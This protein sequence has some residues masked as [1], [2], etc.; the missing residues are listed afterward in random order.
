MRW[1]LMFTVCS[2]GE[3]SVLLDDSQLS[4]LYT[5]YE[6]C[7]LAE[8]LNPASRPVC[9]GP[10]PARPGVTIDLNPQ[11]SPCSLTPRYNSCLGFANAPSFLVEFVDNDVAADGW[12]SLREARISQIHVWGDSTS[13]TDYSSMICN[14]A[15]CA[16][17][18]YLVDGHCFIV[19]HHRMYKLD[20]GVDF[21]AHLKATLNSTERHAHIFNI[22]HH[23]HT[24][25]DKTVEVLAEYLLQVASLVHGYPDV[26]VAWRETMSQHFGVRSG[27]Y[28]EAVRKSSNFTGKKPPMPCAT[29]PAASN[30]YYGDL[31]RRHREEAQNAKVTPVRFIDTHDIFGPR[32]DLHRVKA[33]DCTHYCHAP[34]LTNALFRR[35]A[36]VLSSPAE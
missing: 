25:A 24:P 11:F 3:W 5:Q 28:D 22:G 6:R 7:A 9:R 10:D 8:G 27:S 36:H 13:G 17:G 14:R 33:S 31:K 12:R 23:V 4:A 21:T 2:A 19:E 16:G 1:L 15:Q 20:S 30:G 35:T 29:A 34:T 32:Y 26:V 18:G